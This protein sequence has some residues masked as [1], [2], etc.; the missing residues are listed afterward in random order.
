L[1]GDGIGMTMIRVLLFG[2]SLFLLVPVPSK[3]EPIPQSIGS[4]TLE[5]LQ[6]GEEAR[7]EIDRLHGKQ[8]SFQRGYIGTYEGKDG[9]AKIWVSE[10]ASEGEGVEAIEIMARRLKASEQK[11]FWHF[12]EISIEGVPV[13]F[14]VGMGQ[15]HYFF[16]K[17]VKA[18]WLAVDPALAREAIRDVIG[19]F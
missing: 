17:G 6:S 9:K 11:N 10:Y 12:K 4:L 1:K 8:I 14:V 19:K 13:Y 15:A 7:Q 16:Q 18:I 2:L 5:K 3:G